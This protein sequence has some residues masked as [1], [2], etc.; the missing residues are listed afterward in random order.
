MKK[1]G[2]VDYYISEWHANNYPEWINEANKA[3]GEDFVIAYA[4]AEKDVSPVDGR[5]TDEW[6]KAFGVEKCATIEELCEKSDYILVL[7]PSD[8][9]TH[10]RLAEKVLK[11]GKNTYI[12][13]TF[14]PDYA[15][16]KK[17][18][19][20]GEK[21]GTKFFSTSALRYADELKA[22]DGA[23]WVSVYGGG[24][25]M[26]EYIIH[27]AEMVVKIMGTGAKRVRVD[28]KFNTDR[29][30]VEYGDGRFA[31]M[32]FAQGLGF[33]VTSGKESGECVHTDVVSSFFNNLIADILKF[34]VTGEQPF[35]GKETL[36]VMKIR[37]AVIKAKL[38]G[39][40]AEI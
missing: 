21:Y 8:P 12:D 10:L 36:E 30:R 34:Y 22:H 15:T 25:N 17:I 37:E 26:E 31:E 16:A 27:Q 20:L 1:I 4:W 32:F 2:F 11:Y 14:A 40:W 29:I 19:D 13:K 9:D 24:G 28:D 33:S 18:F 23:K 5:T 35:D 7:A 38:S 6:C 39:E 3:M